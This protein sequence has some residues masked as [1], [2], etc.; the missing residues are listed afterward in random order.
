[1]NQL[2]PAAHT[3]LLEAADLLAS[4]E[5]VALSLIPN[6]PPDEAVHRLFRAFH[7]LK[8]SGAMFG[9]DDVA[10]FTH[11]VESALDQVREGRIALS[12]P[13]IELILASKDHIQALIDLVQ[14]E[15]AAAPQGEDKIL[16]DLR[17]LLS[18]GDSAAAPNQTQP[19]DPLPTGTPGAADSGTTPLEPVAPSC[20]RI[21]FRPNPSLM[22]SGTNPLVLL[23]EL[24]SLGDCTITADVSGVPPLDS[25]APNQ[26]YFAWDVILTTEKDINCVRDVFIFVEDGSQI[27]IEPL[28]SP[29][30]GPAPGGE[31]LVANSSAL[32][33]DDSTQRTDCQGVPPA[34]LAEGLSARSGTEGGPLLSNPATP[35]A[36]AQVT[37]VRVASERLDL[38]V[39]LVGEFV[40]NQS[41]L[42]QVAAGIGSPNLAAPVEALERLVGELRD[43]VLGIRMMPIGTTFGRFKRLVHDLSAELGKEIDLVTEGAE[44]ELDKTVLDQLGDPL[45]HLIRNG[46][47]HAIEAPQERLRIG[48]PRRGTLSLAACHEGARVVVT[49]RDDGRGLDTDAIRAR[50]VEKNLVQPGTV[51]SEKEAFDLIFLP[52]FSTARQVTNVSG[53]GVGMDVVRRQI[54]AL[55]GSIQLSSQTGR[56]MTVRLELPLTLAIIDGLLVEVGGDQFIVPLAAVTENAELH[57]TERR[58]H[59]GRN[60]MSLRG[61]QIPHVRLRE[62]FD[63]G[64]AEPEIEKVAIVSCEGQRLG[65]VVDRVIGIHQTV[66]QSLGRF[67]RGIRA[68]SGATIM[69]DGRVALILDLAGLVRETMAARSP[70]A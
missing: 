21:R 19:P 4:I 22:A 12:S 5:E 53:R 59:N 33:T 35:K 3:F 38:L 34:R 6:Q 1:M 52:G 47:D 14:D 65:V 44:T 31:S 46:I 49:I 2:P 7:T 23:D 32:A 69:G 67:Y 30:I 36:K 64:G 54:E 39:N 40:I 41:R 55:R 61:E 62:V 66:I 56:G 51:L 9:F 63:I 43:T 10:R 50:A 27:D 57:A 24:R 28:P 20:Y 26:C 29:D 16:S 8:G 58:A 37:S 11:H 45:V 42:S 13:L 68:V 70:A 60:L 25:I 15:G 18:P 48:K 17:A